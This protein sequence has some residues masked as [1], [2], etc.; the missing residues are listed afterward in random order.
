LPGGAGRDRHAAERPADARADLSVTGGSRAG[1]ALWTSAALCA[2]AANSLLC[3]QAL[4]HALIDPVGFTLV[5]IVAGAAVL[6]PLARLA[7]AEG[8][9][10]PGT[11]AAARFPRSWISAAALVVYAAAFSWAYTSLSAGTGS[12]IAFAAVQAT[13]IGA[14]V[15]GGERL[16]P[17][18]WT[19][20]AIAMSGLFV[21]LFPGLRAPDPRGALAMAIAGAAWGVYSLRGKSAGPPLRATAESFARGTAIVLVLAALAALFA[22]RETFRF[23][24]GG[25]LLA[26]VSG[27]V[28]SGLGYA[29]WYRALRDLPA[30]AAALVQLAVPVLAA[31][32]GA[33]VLRE[34]M[35]A[36]L[37]GASATV[38]GGIGLALAP[39][40]GEAAVTR[41]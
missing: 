25:V 38:L 12:L 26:V 17:R 15:M 24:W 28:T 6:V 29:V 41:S 18:A 3:R 10:A 1:T 5:R 23:T 32:A 22:G 21:L 36:R 39:R 2:F 4:S 19:G 33:L 20:A 9:V 37:V 13:M 8:A 16:G 27:G 30:S 31:V 14:A 7:R 34:P 11:R 40:R 35:T